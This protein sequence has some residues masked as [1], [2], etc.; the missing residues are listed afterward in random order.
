MFSQ[1]VGKEKKLAP[2]DESNVEFFFNNLLM[3][4]INLSG[5]SNQ[6]QPQPFGV[7]CDGED[8]VF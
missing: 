1:G 8:L 4:K 5:S 6:N 3:A 2:D 7:H